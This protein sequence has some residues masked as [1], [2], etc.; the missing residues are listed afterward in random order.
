MVDNVNVLKYRRNIKY[1]TVLV[2]AGESGV[3][4]I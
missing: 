1:R 4:T 2:R 3:C